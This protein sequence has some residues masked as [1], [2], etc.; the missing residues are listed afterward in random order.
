MVSLLEAS[1]FVDKR[2][3]KVRWNLAFIG[4]LFLGFSFLGQLSLPGERG[5][6]VGAEP[7]D[8]FSRNKTE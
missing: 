7:K 5:E 1:P 6:G 2:N 8:K 3:L 4:F